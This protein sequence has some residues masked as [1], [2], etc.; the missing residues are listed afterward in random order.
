MIERKLT[1]IA[2]LSARELPHWHACVTGR[3]P[4]SSANRAPFPGEIE[5][6]LRRA[7]ALGVSLSRSPAERSG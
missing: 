5:A 2:G 4:F 7:Q 3:S 1:Q 6:L